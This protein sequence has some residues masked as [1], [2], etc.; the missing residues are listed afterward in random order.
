MSQTAQQDKSWSKWHT[1]LHKRLKQN[2]SL[3][4]PNSTLLLAISGGQDS[5]A[6][7]KLINDLKRLHKWKIEIWHGD[8]QWHSQ[9]KKTEE[10]L[11]LWCLNKQISFHSNKARKE[12]VNNEEKARDWRYKNLIIKAKLLSSNNIYF[13]CKRILTGHTATDRAETIIMN[14]ARGTDLIGLSTLKEKRTL[15]NNLELARP[16][17]IFNRNETLEICKEFDLPIWVDPSNENINFT[18]NKI[19]KEILPILNSIYNG[20]D[21]R[22]ASLAYRLESYSDDQKLFAEIAIEFC[23]G[24]Q[25]NSLSRKK[26]I[27]YPNSIRKIILSNWLRQLGVKRLTAIQIEEINNK[28]SQ[29][30]PPGT[31][32]LHGEFLMK[33]NKES[34][35]ISNKAN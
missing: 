23:Q 35:Y 30:K 6:L 2:Q 22:I 28:I 12:E 16:L 8:H 9:S 34:I 18:R 24:D 19:R 3:L 13:P 31:V 10:E 7:L 1:R 20:A 14:L 25:I 11:K 4:P 29:S 21:L 15:E 33:W 17:L 26:I 32:Y 27:K 5:M